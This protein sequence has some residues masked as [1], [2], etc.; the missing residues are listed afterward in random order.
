MTRTT[1]PQVMGAWAS[2]M[3]FDCNV[4]N[5]CRHKSHG[6]TPMSGDLCGHPDCAEALLPYQEVYA[7]TELPRQPGQHGE[8]WVC[9]RHVRPDKGP[10]DISP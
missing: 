6:H 5:S 3:P 7:V 1:E 2:T 4:R 10:V 8:T 9:W